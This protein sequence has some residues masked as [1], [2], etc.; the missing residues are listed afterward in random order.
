MGCCLFSQPNLNYYPHRMHRITPA[1][2]CT[3]ITWCTIL[4][5]ILASRLWHPSSFLS[6]QA[7]YITQRVVRCYPVGKPQ[8]NLINTL[9]LSSHVT[10]NKC[11]SFSPLKNI[12]VSSVVTPNFSRVSGT[13]LSFQS[14]DYLICILRFWKICTLW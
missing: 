8:S 9:P 6:Q 7:L 11:Y 5:K 13:A 10:N 2:G 1:N 14:A 4:S 3:C 12:S